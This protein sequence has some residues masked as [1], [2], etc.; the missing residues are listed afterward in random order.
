VQSRVDIDALLRDI[1][2]RLDPDSI[3]VDDRDMLDRLAFIASLAEL[4][5]YYDETNQPAGNWRALVMKDPVILL[6]VISK[7]PYQHFYEH[8]SQIQPS[9]RQAKQRVSSSTSTLQSPALEASIESSGWSAMQRSA[10]HQLLGIL[11]QMFESLND[12]MRVMEQGQ[13]DYHL[14][15]FIEQKISQLLANSLEQRITM[16]NYLATMLE[17]CVA[18]ASEQVFAGF[19]P[20]WKV[21]SSHSR[22]PSSVQEA[23][24]WLEQIYHRVF[25]CYVQVITSARQAF[26]Q[27]SQQPCDF[28]DTALLIAFHRLLTYS[29][30]GLNQY[31]HKHLQFY[32]Q[33]ILHQQM[34]AATSDRAYLCLTLAP[35]HLNL[36]LPVGVKFTG[37]HYAD[38]SPILFAT[39]RSSEVNQI[40][41]GTLIS[42]SYQCIKRESENYSGDVADS[43]SDT[44]SKE[45]LV[46]RQQRIEILPDSR[47]VRRNASQQILASQWFGHQQ[48]QVIRQGFVLASPMLALGSGKRTVTITLSL[49]KPVDVQQ[50]QGSEC[51]LSGTKAWFAVKKPQW[52]Q[53]EDQQQLRLTWTLLPDEPAVA[54]FTK[55]PAGYDVEL[56]CCRIM[57]PDTL[58]LQT[59]PHL[60]KLDFQVTVE[61]S[62]SFSLSNDSGPLVGG[63]PML[64][65]GATPEVGSHC[66]LSDA[67]A[68]GKPLTQI[69]LALLWEKMPADFSQ[70]YAA[71]NDSIHQQGGAKLTFTNTAFQ[72]GWQV[73]TTTGWQDISSQIAPFTDEPDAQKSE[74]QPEK[75]KK[76]RHFWSWFWH[77][78]WH[79][80]ARQPQPV[81]QQINGLFAQQ[82]V[83]DE[84]GKIHQEN[85]P[86]TGYQLTFSASPAFSAAPLSGLPQL[87]MTL[88]AP[89]KG[90]GH[91][92]YARLVSEIS[93]S[94]AKILMN[95]AGLFGPVVKVARG[96][97]HLVGFKSLGVVQPLPELPWVLKAKQAQ[98]SYQATQ[99]LDFTGST[100]DTAEFALLHVGAFATYAYF[101]RQTEKTQPEVD[102]SDTRLLPKVNSDVAATV[103]DTPGLALFPGVSQDANCL[104]FQLVQVT[105]PCRLSLFIELA[106][107]TES[108]PQQSMIE[109]FYWGRQGWQALAVLLDQTCALTRSGLLQVDL[110][111]DIV[112]NPPQLPVTKAKESAWLMMTQASDR[113]VACVFCNTQGIEVVRQAPI[114]LPAGEA[115]VLAAGAIKA[116]AAKHPTIATVVQPFD[117]FGGRAKETAPDFRARVSLRLKTKN[118]ASSNWDYALLARQ[119]CPN[120]FHVR[121]LGSKVS[122]RVHLGVVQS[123]AS[124][125]ITNAFRPVVPRDDLQQ[126]GAALSSRMSAMAQIRVSNLLH[127]PVT[128]IATLV[129]QETANASELLQTL[130]DGVNLYLAPWIHAEQAQ[131][132]IGDGL[133]QAAVT[134][135]LAGFDGVVAVPS[136]RLAVGEN[137]IKAISSPKDKLS[138]SH[139]ASDRI[140]PSTPEQIFVPASKHLFHLTRAGMSA[141]QSHSSDVSLNQL[142]EAYS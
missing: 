82:E 122:G 116:P 131:Y 50:W 114:P 6:A 96:L 77:K 53:G 86:G 71:Y 69:S 15:Q 30:Q 21:S 142:T 14:R 103:D 102:E 2:A 1:S 121:R 76:S 47:Q 111:Q 27:L 56:P 120:L 18:P 94:N 34:Q 19:L 62:T 38:K 16:Q 20:M 22:Q 97:G 13:A 39:I 90:F 43:P 106:Q 32:Y 12:W 35:G 52:G 60:L 83:A 51:W 5:V 115:P 132:T 138:T 48:S 74:S 139:T 87:R 84:K 133:S 92:L 112:L 61:Q 49:N 98:V 130:N 124:V 9:Y 89:A 31:S 46:R 11:D 81:T 23:M 128:V 107:D 110:P 10:I 137:A 59:I 80:K 140:L 44:Q 95:G 17:N 113:Q 26:A 127:E 54:P 24:D 93:L 57:L 37:G 33:D 108:E 125:Q 66:Y 28:P 135:F 126:I 88:T 79:K 104:Y 42:S 29:Q 8:F 41:L 7:T 100:Q 73:H 141:T 3:L 91:S 45:N 68:F 63:K 55:P 64:I 67:E 4:I 36:E 105:P 117:S 134:R 70:Y 136:L 123:Y 101:Y 40:Q 78:L 75:S 65:W 109:L 118:R 72:A 129:I 25:S 119:A 58:D 99:S 85:A